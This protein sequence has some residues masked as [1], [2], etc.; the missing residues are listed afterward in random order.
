[1][2]PELQHHAS[3]NNYHPPPHVAKE[4]IAHAVRNMPDR[5][6]IL[7]HCYDRKTTYQ[8]GLKQHKHNDGGTLQWAFQN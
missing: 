6:K 8:Q 7:Q 2:F 1:M 3:V 5:A 4:L